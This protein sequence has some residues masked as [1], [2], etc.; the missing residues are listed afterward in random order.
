MNRF[1]YLLTQSN[2]LL[3]PDHYVSFCEPIPPAW[4]IATEDS[5]LCGI[6]QLCMV[7]CCSSWRLSRRVCVQRH[8]QHW[9]NCV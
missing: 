2:N 5:L 9:W 7:L 8:W 3:S 6:L 4:N 1:I